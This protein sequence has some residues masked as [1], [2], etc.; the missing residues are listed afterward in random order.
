M[1][2]LIYKAYYIFFLYYSR[3]KMEVAWYSSIIAIAT[4]FLAIL[5]SIS[6]E[7]GLLEKIDI[8]FEADT[9]L[10][11]KS[12]L[13]LYL[14]IPLVILMVGMVHYIV[15]KMAK[16]SKTTGLS[17]LYIF[18]PTKRDKVVHWIGWIGSFVLSFAPTIIRKLMEG[19]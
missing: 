11:R 4:T 6:N 10:G 1:V 8:Y 15:F 17:E 9:E 19:S 12:N 2:K 16:A 5:L 3:S 13:F 7:L 14:V 18:T